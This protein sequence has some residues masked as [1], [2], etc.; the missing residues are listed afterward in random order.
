MHTH[1]QTNI[2]TCMYTHTSMHAHTQIH[3]HTCMYMHTRMHAHTQRPTCMHTCTFIPASTTHT[4]THTCTET[5]AQTQTYT[6][7]HVH[8]HA[9]TQRHMPTRMYIHMHRDMHTHTCTETHAYTHVHACTHTHA[10]TCIPAC[11][12]TCTKD[13]TIIYLLCVLSESGRN[14]SLWQVPQYNSGVRRSTCQYMS[15]TKDKL[16]ELFC[17]S[18]CPGLKELNCPPLK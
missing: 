15:I 3:M 8:T 12:H 6:L 11:I 14:F 1:I 9:Q 2:H 16:S 10:C 7:M 4:H 5:H 13:T 17:I 18:L